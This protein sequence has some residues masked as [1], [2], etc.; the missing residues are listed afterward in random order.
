[1]GVFWLVFRLTGVRVLA[2]LGL[3]MAAQS[4][5]LLDSADS[6]LTEVHAATLMVAVAALSWTTATALSAPVLIAP[7]R[8]LPFSDHPCAGGNVGE[9]PYCSRTACSTS[10]TAASVAA[11]RRTKSADDILASIKR[12]A[13]RT[14]R[15]Q[16]G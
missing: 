1:M 13:Q 8:S 10:A 9:V 7:V 4:A 14:L 15:V 16:Q 6:F 5:A 11:C 12:V 2:Y 3:L